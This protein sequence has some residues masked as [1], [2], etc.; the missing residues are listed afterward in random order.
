MPTI[1]N[2]E[3]TCAC[4]CG[5]TRLQF[6]S[7]LMSGPAKM[8]VDRAGRIWDDQQRIVRETAAAV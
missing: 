6:V 8:D 2:P 7:K 5:T 1:K 4:G 3:E